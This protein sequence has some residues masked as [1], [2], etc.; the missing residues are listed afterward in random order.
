MLQKIELIIWM[1]K[2]QRGLTESRGSLEKVDP[3]IVLSSLE[4][5]FQEECLLGVRTVR[6]VKAEDSTEIDLKEHLMNADP[7]EEEEAM[8]TEEEVVVVPVQV[9]MVPELQETGEEE[10]GGEGI[11]P[12]LGGTLGLLLRMALPGDLRGRA[13][14]GALPGPARRPP[15]GTQ[16]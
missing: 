13:L 14:P 2:S 1:S 7:M 5:K 9:G 10:E 16:D 4:T 11:P 15:T 8:A 12:V 3:E 6:E